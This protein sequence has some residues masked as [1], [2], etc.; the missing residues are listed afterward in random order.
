MLETFIG[1]NALVEAVADCVK[2]DCVFLDA[3]K[4]K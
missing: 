2:V 3:V 1:C 4:V